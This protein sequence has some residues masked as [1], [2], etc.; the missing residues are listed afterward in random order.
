MLMGLAIGLLLLP[1]GDDA[2]EDAAPDAAPAIVGNRDH[3]D[4]VKACTRGARSR[5][6]PQRGRIDLDLTVAEGA[7]SAV[8]VRA[9]A[10]LASVGACL[11]KR[12]RLWTFPARDEP[13][14]L[15][16]PVII[17]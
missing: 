1:T 12:V 9:P 15:A 3:Q 10:E 8:S 4:A 7:V 2:T 11:E 5:A 16:L 6:A 14:S 17:H 13:Y